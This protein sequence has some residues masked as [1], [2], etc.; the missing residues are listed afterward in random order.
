LTGDR[1]TEDFRLGA[2]VYSSDGKHV[3]TVKRALVRETDFQLRAIVVEESKVFKGH[4][5]APGALGLEDD[6]V[7]P[8]DAV[9]SVTRERVDLALTSAE[10]RQLPPY[11]SYR[12]ATPAPGVEFAS[13]SAA[14]GG[15]PGVFPM[16]EVASRPKGEIEI[17]AGENVMIGRTGHRLGQVTDVLFDGSELIAVVVQPEGFFKKP[18]LLPRRFLSRSDDLSLFVELTEDEMTNLERFK[19]TD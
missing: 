19:P 9:R 1:Q 15:N 3:G 11:L 2:S 10:V 17:D 18:V 12:P 14:V 16:A 4:V 7:V 8:I 5:L 13:W 6:L